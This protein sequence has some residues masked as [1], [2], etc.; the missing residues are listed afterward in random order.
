MT[1]IR[2]PI[3][4]VAKEEEP[5][6][7]IADACAF[8]IRRYLSGYSHGS[9][10]MQAVG[11]GAGLGKKI[12]KTNLIVSGTFCQVRLSTKVNYVFGPWRG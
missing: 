12:D 8:G 11:G 2:L 6:I 5:L 9:D 7:Q 3:H 1:R 10:F 4:F